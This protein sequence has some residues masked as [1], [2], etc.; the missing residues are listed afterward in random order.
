MKKKL[1][2]IVNPIAGMGGRVGLKGTDGPWIVEQARSLGAVP[3]APDRAVD[4]LRRVAAALDGEIE[5]VT[6]PRRMG[7]DEVIG[8]GLTPADVRHET[9]CPT[10]A[11]DTERSAQLM[12][13]AG[14]D[15]ILFA[16]G[17]GTARDIYNA[18][19]DTVPVVGIPAGVKMHSGVYATNPRAAGDL[20][21]RYLKGEGT[22]MREAEVMDI[23]EEAFRKN[24]LSAMLFGYLRVPYQDGLVQGSKDGRSP[25]EEASVE[26]VAEEF[27]DRMEDDL[28]YVLGPG[29]TTRALARRLGLDKTLLGVDI[30]RKGELLRADV[31][32]KD[33][34]ETI[35]GRRAGIVV[36]PIGGQGHIFGRGN[37]QISP[38]VISEVGREKIV[39]VATPEKLASFQGA[40]LL[41]DTG[42]ETVDGML[43]GY[44][45]V[46]TGYRTESVHRVSA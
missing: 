5:V 46:I 14:V 15:L 20:A 42:D 38:E 6:A 13:E 3:A 41:V 37:Q 23:D 45:R 36:T 2:V 10:T 27:A 16:G 44:F 34:L 29:T 21:V 1:G 8:A 33:I 25:N 28:L 19:G 43:T 32:E 18:V 31:T 40:P 30:I 11:R 35:A 39:L 24:A 4:A 12:V 17:D 22:T 9:E 26:E 7:A